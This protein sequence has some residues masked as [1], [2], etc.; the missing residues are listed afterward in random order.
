MQKRPM[1]W[2]SRESAGCATRSAAGTSPEDVEKLRAE[3]D[4]CRL[5]LAQVRQKQEE[6]LEQA[7]LLPKVRNVRDEF[8]RRLAAQLSSEYWREQRPGRA[9]PGGLR[10]RV[11]RFVLEAMRRGNPDE[12]N[13]IEAI[14]Q[15]SYF[16]GAWYLSEYPD[17]A[18]A[19]SSPAEH[20]LHH[21]AAEGRD[22]GPD[23]S[24]VFYLRSHQDVA[25]AGTNPLVH[26]A[27]FGQAEGRAVSATT[28]CTGE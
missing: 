10:G 3:L 4:N 22:P 13:A 20:Y 12:W 23:F 9:L 7:S 19:R 6:W 28:T 21:G 8:A 25:S 18:D 14:E 24:T 2:D 1:Q 17:V 11:A 26:F 27:M 16:D 15:S 5:E